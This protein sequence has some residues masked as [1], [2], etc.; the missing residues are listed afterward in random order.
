MTGTV[1]RLAVPGSGGGKSGQP[2]LVQNSFVSDDCS[3]IGEVVAANSMDTLK[4]S[5]QWMCNV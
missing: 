2:L 4:A 1:G 3:R 5:G